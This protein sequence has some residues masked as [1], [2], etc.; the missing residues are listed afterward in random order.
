MTR[1]NA[2]YCFVSQ[3]PEQTLDA[4]EDLARRVDSG[5]VISLVGDLGAGKTQFVKGLGRGLGLDPVDITS[6]TF[7][8][9]NEYAGTTE[10]A[11]VHMDFYRLESETALEAVGYLDLLALDAIL[12]IE[13]ADRFP[14]ALPA[15]RLEIRIER[16]VDTS[17]T[18]AER[19]ATRVLCARAC[20]AY[21]G[22]LLQ[23]W[24]EALKRSGVETT[25]PD[26]G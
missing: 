9:V 20:G 1:A 14:E 10:R 24:R 6:P 2:D 13:W 17:R 25:A 18:N 4:A 26:E 21:S 19:G 12:A 8:L 15:D 3:T 7:A 5:V 16:P 11:L 23:A 22:T